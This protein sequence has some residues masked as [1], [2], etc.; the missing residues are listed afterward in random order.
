MP[1][2][3]LCPLHQVRRV[4]S[5]TI[6]AH[7]FRPFLSQLHFTFL[8][9]HLFFLYVYPCYAL[10]PSRPQTDDKERNS[11]GTTGH[12]TTQLLGY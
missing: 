3:N 9:P 8:T 1:P 2:S 12:R 4:S 10:M 6:F 11:I 7:I 5:D